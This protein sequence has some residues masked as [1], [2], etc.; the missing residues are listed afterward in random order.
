[1]E[2][3]NIGGLLTGVAL[4][5]AAQWLL[6]AQF[7]SGRRS[8]SW[9]LAA[10]FALS[11]VAL[12]ALFFSVYIALPRISGGQLSSLLGFFPFA[13]AIGLG[14]GALGAAVLSGAF[15]LVRRARQL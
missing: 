10:S 12:G 6:L 11:V 1:M 4:G 13:V 7:W 14:V 9:L 8:G 2:Y 3:F 15:Q 5:F